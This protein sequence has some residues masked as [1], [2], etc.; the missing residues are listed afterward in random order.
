MIESKETPAPSH[1][2]PAKP[3]PEAL[4]LREKG[5]PKNGQPQALDTRL[6]MQLQ[7]FTGCRDALQL[8]KQLAGAGLEGVV[9]EDVNDPRGVGI[10]GWAQQPELFLTKHRPLLNRWP[11]EDLELRP[12]FSML[13]RTYSL[14]Y[15][16][17]LEDWLLERPRRVVTDKAQPWAVWYPLRRNGEFARLSA[18]E[19]GQILKE[20]GIIG[21]RF[22]DAGLAQDIRLNCA[23]LD[24]DDNDFV[25]GLIGKELFPLSALVQAMRPTQQTSRYLSNLGPF[26]VGRAVWQSEPRK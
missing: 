21:R 8:G 5:G 19:Q 6:F 9:Y 25:I 20:H 18:Q 13:G 23:G 14:G 2:L 24:K 12:E 17:S 26:F 11:F 4:D 3:E 1:G 16:P 7:V 22:G 15:E 10:L